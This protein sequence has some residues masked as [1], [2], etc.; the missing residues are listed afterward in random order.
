MGNYFDK[1]EINY[2]TDFSHKEME[3]IYVASCNVQ[4]W[5][6]NQEDFII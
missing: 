1:P 3:R 5:R 2:K 4:G 6:K